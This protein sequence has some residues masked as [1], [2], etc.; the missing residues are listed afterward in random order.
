MTLHSFAAG[1]LNDLGNVKD[2]YEQAIQQ[3][4]KAAAASRLLEAEKSES[5][6]GEKAKG[7]SGGVKKA[8]NLSNLDHPIPGG[9]FIFPPDLDW[10]AV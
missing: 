7:S 2:C 10:I 5:K 1:Q 8:K 4:G 9:L 3:N 6:S